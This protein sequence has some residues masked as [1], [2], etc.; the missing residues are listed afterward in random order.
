MKKFLHNLALATTTAVLSLVFVFALSSRQV[1]LADAK[2]D[3]CKGVG[4]VT[5]DP[6]AGCGDP[7]TSANGVNKII[8]TVV[9]ILSIIV[10]IV[11]VIMIII[12]GFR[13]VLSGGDSNNTNSARNTIIYAIVGLVVVA[14]AQI[15]V[16]Y[17]LNR[18]PSG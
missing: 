9:N 7:T 3:A 6:N 8:G 1:A 10:G 18:V 2:G 4:L 11:A 17:V 14:V 13:F 15:L 12:G 16:R 5:G